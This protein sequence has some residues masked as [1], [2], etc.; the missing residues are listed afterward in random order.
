MVYTKHAHNLLCLLSKL[1]SNIQYWPTLNIVQF[2]VAKVRGVTVTIN[3]LCCSPLKALDIFEQYFH[4]VYP[5]ICIEY[6][7]LWEVGLN[8]G[9]RSCKRI[10]TEKH[11]RCTFLKMHNKKLTAEVFYYWVRIIPL[12]QK[13]YDTSE[14]VVS[15]NVLFYQQLSIAL[16]QVSFLAKNVLIAYNQ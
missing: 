12:S 15:R 2:G 6:T 8:I 16:Y 3:S 5:N 7:N 10:M 14:G 13:L 9:H 1:T 11:P 4:L